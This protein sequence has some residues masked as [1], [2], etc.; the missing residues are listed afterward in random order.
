MKIRKNEKYATIAL[1]AFLTICASALVCIGIANFKTVASAVGNFFDIMAPLTYGFVIAYICTPLLNFIERKIFVFKKAKKD[2]TKLRRVLSVLLTFIILLA[3]VSA[4]FTLL[5][6][7]IVNSYDD[8]SSQIGDYVESAQKWAD[9]FVRNFA[10]FNG[11]YENLYDFLD[12]NELSADIK[13]IISNSYTYLQTISDYIIS[14]GGKVVVEVKNIIIGL[15]L[16]VYFLYS[17]EK[18]AAQLKK[19]TFSVFKRKTYLNIVNLTRYTHEKFGGFITG[20]LL[21]SLIIGL[22]TFIVTGIFGIPFYPLIAVIVGVTNVIPTFGPIIGAIPSAFIVLI[23]RPSKLILFLIIIIVIQQLDG[24]IIGPKILGDSI[25]LGAMWVMIAIIIGGGFFGITG[26]LLGVPTFAVIYALVKQWSEKR[27][28]RRK[29]PADTA[30][31]ANDPPF[32]DF[33]KENVYIEKR[34]SIPENLEIA[35]T[36]TPSSPKPSETTEKSGKETDGKDTENS[37]KDSGVSTNK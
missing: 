33:T 19:L 6:P 7:Q 3:C 29:L 34:E 27:L 28:K 16:A 25:G 18:L 22:L 20:K 1:Y 36:D 15:I 35:L 14:Y 8:L 24:N 32:V 21:D 37:E 12:V 9:D 23:A 11:K 17:K 30:F 26:M 4:F 5:V 10:P 13:S 2:K 31:Y